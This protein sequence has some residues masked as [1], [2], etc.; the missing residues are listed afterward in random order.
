MTLQ[1]HKKRIIILYYYNVYIYVYVYNDSRLLILVENDYFQP[2]S[3]VRFRV[4]LF[5]LP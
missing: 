3:R 2:A 5:L 1:T 4:L